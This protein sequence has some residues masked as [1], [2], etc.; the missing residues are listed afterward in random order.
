L[1]PRRPIPWHRRRLVFLNPPSFF[2]FVEVAGLEH[3]TPIEIS[4]RSTRIMD[5]NHV[6]TRIAQLTLAIGFVVAEAVIFN[7]GAA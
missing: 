6:I 5:F 3:R 4:P 2:A 7:I 1:C